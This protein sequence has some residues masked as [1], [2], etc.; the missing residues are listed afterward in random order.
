MPK[1]KCSYA[2]D[3]PCYFDFTVEAPDEKSA[4]ELATKAL[5]SGTFDP[6]WGKVD[7]EAGAVPDSERVF[8]STQ[9]ED[10]DDGDDNVL[11]NDQGTFRLVEK[12]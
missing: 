9:C 11:V 2:Y 6:I 10:E 12:S 5:Q 4:E 7:E 8:V 3:V 1:F